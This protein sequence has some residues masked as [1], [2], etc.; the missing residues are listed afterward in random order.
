MT[1]IKTQPIFEITS[2]DENDEFISPMEVFFSAEN[3]RIICYKEDKEFIENYLDSHSF[4][5]GT[6]KFFSDFFEQKY[7]VKNKMSKVCSSVHRIYVTDNPLPSPK[8][9]TKLT[10]QNIK[11]MKNLTSFPLERI[12]K[13]TLA[14]GIIINGQIVS[15]AVDNETPLNANI[16]DF[17]VETAKEYRQN[18]Y[19][20]ACASAICNEMLT[21]NIIPAMVVSQ[22][23]RKSIKLAKKLNMQIKN[24]HWCLIYSKN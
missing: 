19:G 6:I 16:H 13:S 22:S 15:I 9:V 8:N 17:A 12:G 14:Y 7:F 3:L 20:Y 18:G 1:K 2:I 4:N 5:N 11:E 10:P 24:Y 23:N 21:K